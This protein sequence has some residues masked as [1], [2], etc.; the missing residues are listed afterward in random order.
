MSKRIRVLIT[1]ADGFIGRNL[2]L[3]LTEHKNVDI[4]TFTRKDDSHSLMNKLQDV[5]CIFH[6]AG[7]SRPLNQ[8]D[9]F[10]SNVKLTQALCNAIYH[11]HH[12]NNKNIPLIYTSSI[13]ATLDNPYGISKRKAE[14]LLQNIATKCKID[15]HIFRLPNV[16]GK[17]CKPNYNSVVATFCYNIANNLSIQVIDATAK[18]NLVY[19][20]DVIRSFMYVMTSNTPVISKDGITQITPTY[21][22]TVGKLAKIIQSFKDSRDNL[23]IDRVGVGL[24]RALYATYTSYLPTQKFSY[25]ITQHN[26]ERGRFVEM[27]KTMDSG[28]FSYFTA[29]PGVTRGVHY[30]HS[31]S[32]KFLV[33]KGKAQFNFRHVETNETYE[34]IT[35]EVMPEIIESIPGWVHAITNIGNEELIVLLWSNEVFDHSNPDTY[36]SFI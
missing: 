29:H 33:V 26:D 30:H 20:D 4:I 6:L 31:K 28:Q 23:S 32:E 34:Y 22:I 35:S 7:V 16:F 12:K 14:Q 2:C 27:L 25:A 1:G 9:F 8:Q 13:Q 17:W 24:T 19:I 5:D 10:S 36:L 15:L 11:T 21:S 3:M 18:I